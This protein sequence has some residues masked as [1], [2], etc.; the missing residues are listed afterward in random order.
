MKHG[1]VHHCYGVR[2]G[3][4]AAGIAG[5]TA[6][7]S[8]SREANAQVYACDTN[9]PYLSGQNTA[10]GGYA[11]AGYSSNGGYGILGQ[12]AVGVSGAASTHSPIAECA[13]VSGV[14]GEAD[15]TQASGVPGGYFASAV[16]PGVVG[17]RNGS[18]AA[19]SNRTYGVYGSAAA[20]DGV[21]ADV[22]SGYNAVAG[23]NDSSGAGEALPQASTP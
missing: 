23:V 14:C 15:S 12:G 11:V 5:C 6:I 8:S 1:L 2:L 7:L 18:V 13:T 20:D 19:A 4:A 9:Q 16:G 17:K 3:L 22:N 21:H 10:S